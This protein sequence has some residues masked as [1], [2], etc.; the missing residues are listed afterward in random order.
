[1]TWV[2]NSVLSILIGIALFIILI[3]INDFFEKR[4]RKMEEQNE[5]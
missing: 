5:N 3:L 4:K 1:M 2:I